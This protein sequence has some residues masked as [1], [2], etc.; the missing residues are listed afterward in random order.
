MSK[1]IPSMKLG[2]A[3]LAVPFVFGAGTLPALSAAATS[4]G[5]TL[6]SQDCA[7]CHGA[8]GKGGVPGAPDF[9]KAGGVLAQ[10]DSVL[11]QRVLDGYSSPGAQ[12]AMPPMKG[13]L[14]SEQVE[15]ILE[16]MHKAFG[17]QPANGASGGSKP[18]R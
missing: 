10:S 17:V 13:Q 3:L 14:S 1:G 15:E 2:K 16:Y 7:M 4:G 9:T 5:A 12:M 8:D 18:E 11:V 6:Y